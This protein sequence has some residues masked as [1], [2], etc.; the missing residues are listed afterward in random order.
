ML[1]YK[2]QVVGAVLSLVL[3]LGILAVCGVVPVQ[4]HLGSASASSTSRGVSEGDSS[5][6]EAARILLSQLNGLARHRVAGSGMQELS[7]HSSLGHIFQDAGDYSK[8]SHHYLAARDIAAKEGGEKL[9]ATQTTLGSTYLNAGKL[10]EARQEL[11]SA[12]L[13]MDRKGPNAVNV[14]WALGNCRREAG[15][16]DEALTLYGK[17]EE[18][19]EQEQQQQQQQQQRVLRRQEWTESAQV[20]GSAG[21]LS[22]IGQAYH[23][24]GQLEK[25][26]SYFKRAKEQYFAKGEH[27]QRVKSDADVVELSKIYNRLGQVLQDRGDVHSAAEHYQKALRLQQKS[28]RSGHP[29][30]AETF[31]NIARNQRDSGEGFA[32]ALA[33]LAQAESL[34]Q[35]HTSAPQY[36]A[37]LSMKADILREE[38]RLEEAEEFARR[39]LALQEQEGSE[40]S[41]EL[42]VALNGLGS[43]LHDQRKY[44]FAVKN[45]MRALAVNMKTVG[46]THPETAATYNNLGNVYQDSGDDEAA[47]R[48]YMKCLEIQKQLFDKQTPSPEIAAS[49]NNIATILVRQ[50]RFQEAEQLLINAVDVVRAAGLPSGSPDRTVYEENLAEVRKHLSKGGDAPAQEVPIADMKPSVPSTIQ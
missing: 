25:A 48:Y 23:S 33:T 27:L 44:K 8:A 30:I 46:T 16:L 12:Y 50:E 35:E 6:P 42:A 47:E 9:V 24:K 28:L 43:I 10:K 2:V 39:A 21:L 40:E 13:L 26:I 19:Q 49:Y 32:A 17:A 7:L 5:V 1:S 41:P 38:G 15:K 22:D 11:E 4:F 14:L 36:A 3:L 45:Y 18:Q 20:D 34:L 37:L 31:M 29:Q